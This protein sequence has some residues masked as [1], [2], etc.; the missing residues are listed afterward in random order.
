VTSSPPNLRSYA[1][2]VVSTTKRAPLPTL[3]S[4]I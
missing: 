2:D 3:Q 4:L 1:R